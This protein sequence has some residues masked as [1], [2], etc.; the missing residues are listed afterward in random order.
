L[1]ILEVAKRV[2]FGVGPVI[3]G[4]FFDLGIQR[5]LWPTLI[6]MCGL[7]AVGLLGLERRVTP[8]ENGRRTTGDGNDAI[9]SGQTGHGNTGE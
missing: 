2:G 5:L 4:A 9:E 3:G 1:S 8:R 6:A 7:L